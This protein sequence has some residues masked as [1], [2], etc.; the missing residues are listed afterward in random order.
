MLRPALRLLVTLPLIALALACNAGGPTAPPDAPPAAIPQ[1]SITDPLPEG[2]RTPGTG[3][4]ASLALTAGSIDF[5][6]LAVTLEPARALTATGDAFDLDA[7][8]FF[9]Y[10]PCSDCV[11]VEGISR[12]P[13]GHLRLDINL[14]HPFQAN[15]G[16]LD[17]LVFDVRG[18]LIVPGTTAFPG[19]TADLDGDGT[20]APTETLSG[21]VDLVLNADGYTTRFDARAEDA[22]IWGAPKNIAGTINPFRRYFVDP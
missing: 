10:R 8:D 7:T 3:L 2:L 6:H 20:T 4:E 18:I 21:N 11:R 16:R 12:T 5:D 17:L 13:E 22:A 19:T 14:R 1:G 15:S 9:M